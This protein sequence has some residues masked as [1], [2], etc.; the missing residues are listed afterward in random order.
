[1]SATFREAL[2]ELAEGAPIWP[3][4][5]RLQELAVS[6]LGL[7]PEHD[8]VVVS[9]S[10]APVGE[11]RPGDLLVRP[12]PP[13]RQRYSA[14]I[15]ATGPERSAALRSRGVPVE[16]AGAGWY[17]EV[18]E[19]PPGGG[20]PRSVGRLLTDAYGRLPSGQ[21]VLRAGATR[22]EAVAPETYWAE[23]D[24][25]PVPK[26]TVM[27][28][29]I[30]LGKETSIKDIGDA[31]QKAGVPDI[32]ALQEIGVD[33][34]D[35]EKIDQP[36]ALAKQLGF[37]HHFFA[38]ALTDD[39]G[40]RYGIAL[41]SKWPF[42]SA[43]VTLLPRKDLTRDEQRVLLRARV[44]APAPFTVLDTHLNRF[45][46]KDRLAQAKLV[47]AMAAAAEPPVLLLGDFNDDPSSD[48]VKSAGGTLI[49]CFAKAGSGDPETFSVKD[50]K[51]RID[52]I[53]CGGGLQ[54][55][56]TVRVVREAKASDHFP[57]SAVVGPPPAP[58]KPAM[59]PPSRRFGYGPSPDS[60]ASGAAPASPHTR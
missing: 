36:R 7:G 40:G 19:A 28:W 27:T 41:L 5:E 8:L 3:D 32:L 16:A 37:P 53:F 24:P 56:G 50:P 12:A 43:D 38:G 33:W 58:A 2:W 34:H 21:R 59:R 10:S 51:H 23:D 54:P 46:A 1:M 20:A 44:A 9:R 60:A 18:A 45:S 4:A 17:V 55:V 29:N 26:L 52:Y 22:G 25:V 6:L 30:E 35:G 48:A 14:V 42:A 57:V 47:G 11:V 31:V 39:K 49:D 15:V 13:G